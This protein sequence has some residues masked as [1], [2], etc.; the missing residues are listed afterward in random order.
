MSDSRILAELFASNHLQQLAW[1]GWSDVLT[2]S[3][4]FLDQLER[5][6]PRDATVANIFDIAFDTLYRK[7]PIEYVYKSCILK[8]EVIDARS[9]DETAMYV[10]FPIADARAD[11]LFVNGEATVFEVKTRF[12][13]IRRIENQLTEYFRCFKSVCVVVEEGQIARYS[14]AIPKHVGIVVLSSSGFLTNIMRK[15]KEM[16][17]SLDHASMFALMHKRE[18][19]KAVSD[20]VDLS[21]VDPAYHYEVALECFK[22]FPVAKAYDAVLTALRSRQRTQSLVKLCDRLPQSLHASVFSYR[23]RKQDWDS[24]V[25]VLLQPP[26]IKRKKTANVFSISKR[27]TV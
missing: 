17:D 15:P 27:Q 26:M 25:S 8:K 1:Y 23:I 16:T 22:T 2:A 12:D 3:I 5:I 9:W 18:Y 14:H 4:E 24:L 20:C 21:R 13:N 6:P 10:E 7:Y 11:M 19:T